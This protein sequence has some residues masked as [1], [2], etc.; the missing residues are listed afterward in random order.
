MKAQLVQDQLFT[1]PASPS[2]ELIPFCGFYLDTEVRITLL[3]NA[4]QLIVDQLRPAL[5][6][7][8]LH[9][10]RKKRNHYAIVAQPPATA[11]EG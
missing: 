9:G 3:A 2:R 4:E 1:S 11:H 10:Q 7:E 8:V 5:P 6:V